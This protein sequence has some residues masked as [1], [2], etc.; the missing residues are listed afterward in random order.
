MY[1]QIHT[2]TCIHTDK[3]DHRD[4]QKVCIII[5]AERETDKRIDTIDGNNTILMQTFTYIHYIHMLSYIF[6][7]TAL[8]MT[9]IDIYHFQLGKAP[10][11]TIFFDFRLIFHFWSLPTIYFLQCL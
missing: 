3:H 11:I 9:N 4:R 1:S 8:F 6:I 5:Q 2:D 10:K 7:I